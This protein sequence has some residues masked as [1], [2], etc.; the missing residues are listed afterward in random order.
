MTNHSCNKRKT[1]QLNLIVFCNYV[2]IS[3]TRMISFTRF[4]A[5]LIKTTFL[6]QD[7]KEGKSKAK[8]IIA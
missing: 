1:I 6:M 4:Q 7:Q 8:K 5:M 2:Y 3:F